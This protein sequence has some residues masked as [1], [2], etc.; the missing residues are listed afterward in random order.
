MNIRGEGE[1]L[2]RSALGLPDT[3]DV[4]PHQLFAVFLATVR[5]TALRNM[6][7]ASSFKRE[8][9]GNRPKPVSDRSDIT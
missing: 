1:I 3:A 6:L 5:H 2:L 4:L 8:P 9:T 7:V